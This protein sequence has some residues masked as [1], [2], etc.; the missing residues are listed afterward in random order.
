MRRLCGTDHYP[1]ALLAVAGFGFPG[2][3]PM[4]ARPLDDDAWSATFAAARQHRLTGLLH[5]AVDAGVLPTSEGQARQ[6][7]AAYRSVMLR[8]L[9]LER[10]L[11][12]VVDR[13]ATAGIP[14]RVL[15]GSAV[16]NLDYRQ[17]AL[18]SFV[19]LDLLV[20]PADFDA[21]VHALTSDGF[22]RKLAEP[23][24][25]FDRRFDKGTTLV[26]GTGFEV[27]LHRTFVLGPWGAL[28]DLD[29][30]WAGAEG[31]TVAGRP[32]LALS[33]SN[34]FL[35]ACYHATLGDW[36]LRLASLRD[37]AEMLPDAELGRAEVLAT[38]RAWGGETVVAS[39]IADT[40]RLL[41]LPA[42]GVLSTWA[43]DHVPTRRDEA[44]LAL[45]THQDKTFAAQAL[46]T[47]PALPGLRDKAAYL[48]ALLA[49]DRQYTA[50]RHASTLARFRFAIREVRR[51][52]GHHGRP[53]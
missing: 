8:V 17:P 47:I 19:D 51:G 39:A 32:L 27:D 6:A 15:K 20:R 9:A 33:R 14:A 50:D 7:R 16:A 45:Y 10:E 44:R 24:P 21:A 49:P 13:L 38:A 42:T 1:A 48:R 30:L 29:S 18:R 36:P 22:R 37:V 35:H 43:D 5:A 40:R 12:A 11:L 4:P 2:G 25:G 46:A 23:R 31:F 3:R 41:R 34:R 53:A 26:G 52:R 28:V